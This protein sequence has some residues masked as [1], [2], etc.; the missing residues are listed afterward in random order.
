[1]RRKVSLYIAGHPVDLDEQSFIL[2]NYTMEEMSNPAIV[3]NSFSQSITLK[4]TPNNNK[5]FGN[6][7]KA[8][9]QTQYSEAYT[10]VYFDP[11]RKTP[12]V[13]YNEMNE[14][15][16]EGY[17][18]LNK[19]SKKGA[20]IEYN[21]TLYGGLGSFFYGLTYKEDGSKKTL[22]DLDYFDMNGRRVNSFPISPD[23]V[24]VQDAWTYLAGETPN[25]TTWNIINF[26]PAYN[27]IPEKFDAKKAL[28]LNRNLYVNIPLTETIDGVEY[29][30]KSDAST[31]LM[32]F[33]NDHSE[34]ELNDLR[35]YLQRPVMS[36]KAIIDAICDTYNNGGFQVELDEEFFNESNYHYKD[37]WMSLQMIAAE[38]RASNDCLTNVVK[39]SVSPAEILISY[40]KV[41]GLIFLYNNAEKKVS[42]MLR[43]TFYQPDSMIDLTSRIQKSEIAIN[44]LVADSL[45]YQFGDKTIGQFADEYKRDYMRDYGIQRVNTGFQFDSKTTILT[46]DL[47]FKDAVDVMEFNR[48]FTSGKFTRYGNQAYAQNF[49]LP[50]YENVSIQLWGSV[51]GEETSTDV[52]MDAVPLSFVYDNPRYEF[53]DWLPKVQLHKDN[54]PEDGSYVLLFFAGVKNTP[55]YKEDY[56]IRKTYWLTNDHP[57][58]TLLNQGNPCWNLTGEEISLTSLPSFRRNLVGSDNDI[59]RSWEWGVPLA[60]AVPGIEGSTSIY[61]RWWKKYLTD[62]YDDD[63]RIMTCKVDLRGLFVNQSLMRKIF[64]YNNSLWRLNKIVNH[65]LTT[66]D[67]TECEFIKIQDINN[68][69]A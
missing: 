26:A 24:S 61:E 6:I 7:F 4:G 50:A 56:N 14:I 28:V 69:I 27:G 31:R 62:L 15:L 16:E 55:F 29:G 58:M 54:K 66:W 43:K 2:F 33:T 49:L 25:Y 63:T 51:D 12:F 68:Y 5:V 37:A 60:R 8:D 22:A 17:I 38:D 11:A 64:W 67:D 18:K 39:A 53:G 20:G 57:D 44:P 46:N 45:I 13:V 30:M 3:R 21:I 35:W 10:G 9:R 47:V 23:A 42:I 59:I 65:S 52:T 41:F 32:S 1:M 36:I 34:W 40:A 19:V 48:M